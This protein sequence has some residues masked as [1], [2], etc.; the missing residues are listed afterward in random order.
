MTKLTDR[1]QVNLAPA[2]KAALV[3]RAESEQRSAAWV[4]RRAVLAYLNGGKAK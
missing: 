2:E 4:A 3:K 1:V